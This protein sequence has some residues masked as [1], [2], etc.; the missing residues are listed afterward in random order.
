MCSPRVGHPRTIIPSRNQYSRITSTLFSINSRR[1]FYRSFVRACRSPANRQPQSSMDYQ[2]IVSYD[3]LLSPSLLK[4]SITLNIS[5]RPRLASMVL[6]PM[7]MLIFSWLCASNSFFSR[8]CFIS[9]HTNTPQSDPFS[10]RGLSGKSRK[11]SSLL[12]KVPSFFVVDIASS[13]FAG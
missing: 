5:F 2:R 10:C 1:T 4:S 6:P 7:D 3:L 9:T 12:S 11:R 13:L 8:R